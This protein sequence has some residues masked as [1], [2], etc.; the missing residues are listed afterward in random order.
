VGASI[1]AVTLGGQGAFALSAAGLVRVPARQVNVVD[2]VGAGDA[3]MAGLIDA[4]WTL[5]LLG[6]QKRRDLAAIGTDAL[7]AVLQTAVLSAALTVGRAGADLPDRATR[8]AAAAGSG[9]ILSE[10][11]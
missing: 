7:T 10:P 9:V 5:D 6:A 8:D 1:V 2:T 4:L 3:F 11:G